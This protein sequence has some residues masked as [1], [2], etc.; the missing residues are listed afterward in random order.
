MV[1]K[2]DAETLQGFVIERTDPDATVYTDDAKAYKGLPFKHESVN[3]SAGEYVKDNAHTNGIESFWAT[4][5]RAHTGVYHQFSPKHLDRYVCE[6]A[7]RHNQRS[8][9]TLTQMRA[10]V[11]GLEGKRLRYRELIAGNGLNNGAR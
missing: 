8:A 6:F 10:I 7:G 3:H 4:M 11:L 2:T 1:E 5:R 9:N